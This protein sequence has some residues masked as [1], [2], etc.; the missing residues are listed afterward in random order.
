MYASLTMQHTARK[1]RKN[2][3]ATNSYK[4]F[5]ATILKK[6]H[7]MFANKISQNFF[8]C[9]IYVLWLSILW[10]YFSATTLH[11]QIQTRTYDEDPFELQLKNGQRIYSEADSI[12]ISTPFKITIASRLRKDYEIIFPDSNS[13]PPSLILANA[14]YG[15]TA[16]EDS[17][18][19]TFQYFGNQDLLL[20]G[21]QILYEA[22]EDTFSITAP[23]IRLPFS[24]KLELIIAR[25]DSL[26]LNPIKPNYDF[27]NPWLFVLI[28]GI[29]VTIL[30]LLWWYYRFRNKAIEPKQS[31]ELPVYE[32][33]LQKLQNELESI[34]KDDFPKTDDN[35]KVYYLRIS[36]AFRDYYE[37][38]YGFP[39]LESTSRELLEY[40]N[41]A[42]ESTAIIQKIRSLLNNADRVKFA[43]YKPNEEQIRLLL[44][45]SFACIDLLIDRHKRHLQAHKQEFE[46]FHGYPQNSEPGVSL[47]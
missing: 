2:V 26:E 40:L 15:S 9:N 33:P 11:A 39:A 12:S 27:I 35:V 47:Q 14:S 18:V 34:R 37:T 28:L 8:G 24:S 17:V 3:I 6:I 44:D 5:S 19:Y 43:K 36:D 38:L 29:V 45:E 41:K 10:T 13:F 30:V 31:A 46:Q 23:P 32:S 25:G 7:K 4:P 42:A 22:K 1:K 16:F 21:L 20:N